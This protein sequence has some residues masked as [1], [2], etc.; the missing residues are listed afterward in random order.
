MKTFSVKS[1]FWI[2]FLSYHYLLKCNLN[3]L[4]LKVLSDLVSLS[5]FLT[6]LMQLWPFSIQLTAQEREKCILC[7]MGRQFQLSWLFWGAFTWYW[8]QG[9]QN[10]RLTEVSSHNYEFYTITRFIVTC[11]L[12]VKCKR[13]PRL[14]IGLPVKWIYNLIYNNCPW[15]CS[16]IVAL[17]VDG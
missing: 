10:Q 1:L 17:L 8:G 6:K 2:A 5:G 11:F 7:L 12:F 4:L 3:F 14:G 15:F 9:D 16:M 13:L